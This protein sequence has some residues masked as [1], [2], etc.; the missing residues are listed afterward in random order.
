MLPEPVTA[1]SA[2][3]LHNFVVFACTAVF[4]DKQGS[5]QGKL[6]PSASALLQQHDL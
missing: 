2:L 4:Y 6:W 1:V 3:F 5:L